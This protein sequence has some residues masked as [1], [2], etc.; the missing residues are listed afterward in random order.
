ML[1][2]NRA[3]FAPEAK[4]RAHV[5]N[6]PQ[7][8]RKTAWTD[9]RAFYRICGSVRCIERKCFQFLIVSLAAEKK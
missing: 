8:N 5:D 2:Q 1:E 6:P 3:E 7:G 4:Y 9:P